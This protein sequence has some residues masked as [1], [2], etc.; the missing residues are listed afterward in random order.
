MDLKQVGCKMVGGCKWLRMAS[1]K[2]FVLAAM[3]HTG[4]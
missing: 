2:I 3:N 1:K 4:S